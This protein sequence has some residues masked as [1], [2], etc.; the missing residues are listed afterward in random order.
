MSVKKN[1]KAKPPAVKVTDFEQVL[2]DMGVQRGSFDL[3]DRPHFKKTGKI[4]K[5][6]KKRVSDML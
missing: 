3:Y 5:K 4:K 2:L 6:D 1:G